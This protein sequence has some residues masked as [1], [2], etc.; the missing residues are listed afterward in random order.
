M[1]KRILILEDN[2]DIL[3]LIATFLKEEGFEVVTNL[4]DNNFD[5]MLLDLGLENQSGT[6]I[7]KQYNTQAPIILVSAN[8]QIEEIAK[9]YNVADFVSKPFDLDELLAKVK[10]YVDQK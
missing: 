10:K 5:L 1:R 3:E 9:E 8:S 4:Q 2:K 6:E 7:I